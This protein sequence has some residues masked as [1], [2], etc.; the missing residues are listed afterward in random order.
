[1]GREVSADDCWPNGCIQSQSD[2]HLLGPGP[3][4]IPRSQCTAYVAGGLDDG[5][6]V[7]T[8]SPI[9]TSDLPR[10]ERTSPPGIRGGRSSGVFS[11]HD[12][13]R[14]P[15]IAGQWQSPVDLSSCRP[16]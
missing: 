11:V 15:G 14:W 3:P 4:I 7:E 8:A 13:P 5:D 6:T 1:M 16:S 12:G 10:N 9:A 2:I